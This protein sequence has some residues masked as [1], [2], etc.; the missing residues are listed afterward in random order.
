MQVDPG[1]APAND[2]EQVG[3]VGIK[4]QKAQKGPM[5]FGKSVSTSQKHV[6]ANDHEASSS[7]SKD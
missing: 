6:L 5:I 3:D 4:V 1:K 7:N 2:V